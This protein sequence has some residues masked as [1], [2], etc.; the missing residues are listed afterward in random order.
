MSFSGTHRRSIR[1]IK[2]AMLVTVGMVHS[3]QAC[4]EDAPK[5]LI[6]APESFENLEQ[7]QTL[8]VDLFF[9]ARRIGE[10]LVRFAPDGITFLDV[11][12]VLALLPAMSDQEIV[13]SALSKNSLPAN[14]DLV[15]RAAGN[16]TDCG[17][18]S[19]ELVG[20]IVDRDQFRVDIFVNP[21]LLEV[22]EGLKERY[23][24]RSSDGIS[25]VNSFG[26]VL[27]G[28][29]GTDDALN[30][31][32][33]L[34]LASG[35]RRVRA[36]LTYSDEYGFGAERIAFEWDVPEKR[37]TA[38][39]FW[40][41]GNALTGRR[42][43]I[44]VGIE[45]QIDTRE[46]KESILGSPVIVFLERRARVDLVRDGRVLISKVYE[47]GNQLLDTSSLPEGSYEILLR[48][49][50]AGGIAR[51]ERR[52][53]TKSRRIPA[54]GR[55]DF[56]AFGGFLVRS[57]DPGS[58]Q[59]SSNPFAQVGLA[60][61]LSENW[62]LDGAAQLS[63]AQATIDAGLTF[64]SSSTQVRLA[65]I[66][67]DAGAFGAILQLSSTGT[68]RFNYN[69]DLRR[70]QGDRSGQ[71]DRLTQSSLGGVVEQFDAQRQSQIRGYTQL[72]GIVS[73]STS[74]LRLLGTLVYRDQPEEPTY[75]SF[76]PSVEW[77]VLRRE[78][79]QVTLRTDVTATNSG[80]SGFAGVSL[81]LTGPRSTLGAKIG[82]RKS[83]I[84]GDN[85]GNGAVAALTGAWN[86]QAAGGEVALGA[87][88]E[89]SPDEDS[90]VFSSELRHQAGS[91]NS[92]IVHTRQGDIDTTQYAVGLQT[93]F[94]AGQ[95]AFEIAGR[96]TTES[97]IV[98]QVEGARRD[99][100]FDLV[101]DEQVIGTLEGDEKYAFA[102]PS[103]R[104]Y[105]VRLRPIGEGL[106]SYDGS[107]RTIGLYP[108]V[109]EK[110]QWVVEPISIKFGRLIDDD[111]RP[112]RFA[113]ITGKGVWSE[114]DDEGYF[115]I[116]VADNAELRIELRNGKTFVLNLPA[117][118][119]GE[120][121]A[122]LGDIVCC[123]VP[124]SQMVALR[125]SAN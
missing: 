32:N 54:S 4:A 56:F 92:D 12:Q 99:D 100:K 85:I 44:G 107:T 94:V 125:T 88:V 19:P 111:G 53:F 122:K 102:L 97:M 110:L 24:P 106:L 91:F 23:I 68:S 60:F 119:N 113:S 2:I 8:L 118:N 120:T 108:G 21:Q 35:D 41:P 36:D 123:K 52:F 73:Y 28:S 82:G 90:F 18:L 114:T 87:G 61:R 78:N 74:N 39:A 43:L 10:T 13:G 79:L 31:Q 98:A 55:Y 62:A 29:L 103:Y 17:R 25:L 81:R 58:L 70:I 124:Q 59:F 83:G 49:E 117:A 16:P 76:G 75:Y 66:A 64:L 47:A 3:S 14:A 27:T 46:D 71:T 9:G 45:T 63:E 109:V 96:T 26:G 95:G 57:D 30:L 6:T 67:E 77:D 89:H 65:A 101:V 37:Y 11:E 51:E 115:Q 34:I 5:F 42:K 69:F 50:E 22:N 20:V 40:A 38:G 80:T 7:N 112:V 72:G 104:S 105:K 93:T 33:R 116:E 121:L 1:A 84:D 48:I 86:G 15:C